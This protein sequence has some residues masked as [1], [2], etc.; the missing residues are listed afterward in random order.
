MGLISRRMAAALTGALTLLLA[1]QVATAQDYAVVLAMAV[2][3][4]GLPAALAMWAG[5][6]FESRLV[7]VVLAALTLTGQ[8]LVSVVGGPGGAGGAWDPGAVL[9]AALA[10][11]VLCLA[12]AD[13]HFA[14]AA[15]RSAR[16]RSGPPYAL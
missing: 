16:T 6:G 9:V 10:T 3:L 5:N 13:L 8:I 14:V 4:T 15:S 11:C 12:A 1:G 2:V 7:A